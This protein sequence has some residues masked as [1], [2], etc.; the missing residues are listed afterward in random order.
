MKLLM[1]NWR[2][3]ANPKSGGAE[4]LTEGILQKLAAQGWDIT[5]FSAEFPGSKSNE[6]KDGYRIIRKGHFW[7]V[8]FWAFTYW[9]KHFRHQ[10]FDVV[11]D[12]IH[13]PP[14]FAALYIRN[15]TV[16]A[17]I[18]EVAKEIWFSMYRPPISWIGYTL[19]LLYLKLYRSTSFITVSPSTKQDLIEGGIPETRIAIIPEAIHQPD[20]ITR[21]AKET[22]PTIM[23][24]GRLAAMK[25]V[26]ELIDAVGIAHQKIPALQLW[27]VGRGDESYVA[28]LKMKAS[29]LQLPV[30]F[31]G[32]V[33]EEEKYNLL[34]RAWMLSS[35]SLKEGFGL[36]ILEAATM[37]TP[38][39]VYNVAGFRD[40]VIDGKT[41][42]LCSPTAASLATHIVKIINDVS[43]YQSLSEQA[44]KYST[45]FTFDH[46]A[47]VFSKTIKQLMELT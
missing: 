47:T 46:A 3:L 10:Q 28:A 44:R 25:R 5:L 35:T 7:S 29:T 9:F 40:A 37:G 38:S 33:S 8:H 13:G 45:Q 12:Q 24:I 27:L 32:R 41:G 15:I 6:V 11:V 23:Y 34:S 17:F 43:L 39:V 30:I 31:F 22:T 42:V 18:H 21:S 20:T 2:D 14:F 16:V 1:L 26:E 36:V 4:V 19:E